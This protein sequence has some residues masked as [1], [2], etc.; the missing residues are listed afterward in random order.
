MR[1][2]FCDTVPLHEVTLH[3]FAIAEDETTNEQ[4]MA[5]LDSLGTRER[6]ARRPLVSTVQGY[7]ELRSVG[8]GWT[9]S[10][11][12]T[13]RLYEAQGWKI[14]YQGR[15]RLAEQDWRRFPVAGVGADDAKAYVA[16]LAASGRVPKA[17]LCTEVEWERA[18]RGA[19]GRPYPMGEH[20]GAS[21]ANFDQTYGRVT[22][23]FGPDQVGVHP[24]SNSP[25]GVSD[26]AGNVWE[27]VL[28]SFGHEPFVLRGGGYFHDDA[29]ARSSN[30]HVIDSSARAPYVGVR[31]CA[32]VP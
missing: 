14:R 5:Y 1:R 6:E 16:W 25:F 13:R 22:D 29:S 11:R 20:L 3:S 12:P 10:M 28:P 15:D 2:G 30:R 9:L 32:D 26:L 27:I 31:V 4:W 7:L 17:R 24:D 19:D 18:A 8:R 21:Q 23:A